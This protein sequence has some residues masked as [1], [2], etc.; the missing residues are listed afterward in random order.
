MLGGGHRL[1]QACR[2]CATSSKQRLRAWAAASLPTT[3]CTIPSQAAHSSKVAHAE[4]GG[5]P[6][7]VSCHQLLRL[8]LAH[9]QLQ[10][11]KEERMEAPWGCEHV[12]TGDIF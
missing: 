11:S 6:Q 8:V 7:L 2:A 12:N 1:V 4:A 10:G 3:R 5:Q 9:C